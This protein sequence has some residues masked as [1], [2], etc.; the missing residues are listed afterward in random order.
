M[1]PALTWI[2]DRRKGMPPVGNQ[3]PRRTC[4]AWAATTAHEQHSPEPFSV[5]YLHWAC[6]QS[7][8]GRGTRPGLG[9]AL[10]ESGQPSADQWPYDP[11]IDDTATTYRPPATVTGP[12]HGAN[13]QSIH[14]DP[15]SL[16]AELNSGFL[17]VAAVRITPAFLRPSGGVVHGNH[18]GADGHAV[19]VVG[20]AQLDHQMSSLPAGEL[21]VCVRNSW[22]LTWG[23]DGHALVTETA[24]IACVMFAVVI[25]PTALV[26]RSI[27]P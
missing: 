27:T 14:H 18:P 11:S 25:Q 22:G 17:P 15:R 9:R 10:R 23:R 20:I 21:V 19:T 1:S 16:A 5:E 26:S 6:G 2:A 7:P 8:H 4:L 24:W 13:T 12:F 3:G